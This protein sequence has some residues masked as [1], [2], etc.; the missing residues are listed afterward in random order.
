MNQ[1]PPPVP[2]PAPPFFEDV[3]FLHLEKYQVKVFFR[4]GEK[5]NLM[6]TYLF[7]F[8]FLSELVS[9]SLNFQLLQVQFCQFCFV[10]LFHGRPWH[11]R[12]NSEENVTKSIQKN[13]LKF[14]RYKEKIIFTVVNRFF[15]FLC[16]C[17]FVY[18]CF[19]GPWLS[20]S[21]KQKKV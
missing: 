17:Q 2:F 12:I 11:A 5:I 6:L 18:F 16:F 13:A 15:F 14:L 4:H 21:E 19:L 8:Q 9:D 7:K 3:T 20:L 10:S 1:P